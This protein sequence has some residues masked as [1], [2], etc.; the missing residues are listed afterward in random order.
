MMTIFV[1]L[2]LF[3]VLL[4]T[5]TCSTFG[6][7]CWPRSASFHHALQFIRAR[8]NMTNDLPSITLTLPL[9]VPLIINGTICRD[10]VLLL[11]KSFLQREK[12]ALK[13]VDAWGSKPPAGILEGSHLWLGSY[14]ECLHSLYLVS[15]RSHVLQPYP[16][17]YCTVSLHDD[18][19]DDSVLFRKPTL[20]VGICLPHSCHSNDFHI[21]FVSL[22]RRSVVLSNSSS[23]SLSVQCQ[24]DSRSLPVGA[25]LTVSLIT[26][27]LF[28]TCLASFVPSLQEYSAV[29]SFYRIF[30]VN[31][32]DSKYL[33][34]N[35]V[36]T[37]SLLWVI[38]GH[39]YVFQLTMS[40]NVIHV[41]D[42]LQNSVPL[43]FIPGAVF[44]VDTFFFI[45]G[46][47]AV[48]ILTTQFQSS[49]T[50]RVYHLPVY[51]LHR[52][53]RLIPTLAFVL[54]ISIHLTPLMGDGP[55]FPQATGFEVPAC[56]EQ[57]WT[58]MLFVNNLVSPVSA[59]LPVTWYL[60]ND[61]QFHLL[62]P[63]LLLPL[64]FKRRRV[65]YAL[66][67]LVLVVNVIALASVISTHPGLENGMNQDG[68][69]SVD[70]FE[71]IYITPWCR[72]GPFV[73][74]MLT[75]LFLE[76]YQSS[77]SSIQVILGT[78]VS[79]VLAAICIF[80]PFFSNA[81]PHWS[82]IVYQSLSHQCWS[83]AFA[84]LVLVCS[85]NRGGLVTR[86]LSWPI[87]SILARL[88]YAAYLIH[89]TIILTQVYN[90]FS[91][92]HYQTGVLLDGFLSQ[93]VLTFL[94]SIVVVILVERPCT[95]LEKRLRHYCQEKKSIASNQQ[96]Y[97]T[98]GWRRSDSNAAFFFCS[99]MMNVSEYR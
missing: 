98:L 84:W 69:P 37:L 67:F 71:K 40:D 6:S 96:N 48:L 16:T 97:G 75:K 28:F 56:R 17:R 34:L 61:F 25:I 64:L 44:A 27:L 1:R 80:F 87:W 23:S 32:T 90:R 55:I 30:S 50:F 51:Y 72:I 33:F 54:L 77:L 94:A 4:L 43:Q 21:R 31:R 13:V 89:A 14:D 26:L 65:T 20:I 83:V 35:G 74:G 57:W 45:S 36:R 62:A 41:L 7:R 81:F 99:K 3:V 86:V 88:S 15:N 12:W 53:C 8:A 11:T 5:N 52:Y 70:F 63:L 49:D 79:V 58:T 9:L 76:H 2:F 59:C 18:D 82:L 42:N 29:T 19:D 60:A 92:V 73:I 85:T 10:D 93:T 95:V 78:A 66:L 68:M 47:L 38:L 39:S 91:V 24:S 46:F 22:D